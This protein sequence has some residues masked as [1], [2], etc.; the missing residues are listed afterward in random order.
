MKMFDEEDTAIL[1]KMKR[2]AAKRK[3][4]FSAVINRKDLD[5]DEM[6]DLFLS[7]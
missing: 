3:K 6:D 7:Y 1:N 4:S 5:E 2:Y